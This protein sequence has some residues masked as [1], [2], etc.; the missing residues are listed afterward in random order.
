MRRHYSEV[1]RIHSSHSG[2]CCISEESH[3]SLPCLGSKSDLR[4]FVLEGKSLWLVSNQ[5]EKHTLEP[6]DCSR[7]GTWAEI[8]PQSSKRPIK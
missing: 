3:E 5:E 1:R 4:K 8:L 6:I 2:E 7:Q